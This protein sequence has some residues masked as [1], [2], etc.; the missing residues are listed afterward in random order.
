MYY[1]PAYLDV[2]NLSLRQ[3]TG[4]RNGCSVKSQDSTGVA[5]G[6]FDQTCGMTV[7]QEI[8]ILE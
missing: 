1:I 8:F 6:C 7:V 5:C 4:R 2:L 3:I